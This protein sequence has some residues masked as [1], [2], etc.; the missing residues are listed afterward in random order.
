MCSFHGVLSEEQ[1]RLK[2]RLGRSLEPRLQKK[3]QLDR[4]RRSSGVESLLPLLAGEHYRVDDQDDQSGISVQREDRKRHELA[5][6]E[7]EP[8][9]DTLGDFLVLGHPPVG[10]R[11]CQSEVGDRWRVH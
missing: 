3:V 10:P 9:Q 11:H 4:R 5:D 6:L 1:M 8:G 7:R 2:D